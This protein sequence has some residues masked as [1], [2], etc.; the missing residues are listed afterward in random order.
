MKVEQL[1]FYVWW[2]SAGEVVYYLALDFLLDVTKT[3]KKR[4][5]MLLWLLG[6]GLM[7]GAAV[8]WQVP[9]MFLVDLLFLC[10]FARG[11]FGIAWEKLTAP[12]LIL[13]TLYTFLEGFSAVTMSWI[14]RN[15]M[16]EVRGRA[17]QMAVSA[18]LDA[19]YFGGLWFLRRRY[20]YT[21]QKPISSYLYI[22]L[23]PGGLMVLSIRY[24][25]KLDS[26]AFEEYLSGFGAGMEVYV[27]LV[28][29]GAV[30]LFFVMIEV[31]CKIIALTEC[32]QS[33]LILKSQVEGQ[34]IYVEEA[35]KRQEQDASFRHDIHNHLLVLAG[36]IHEE[37]Y[38]KAQEYVK[39]LHL[40]CEAPSCPVSTGSAALDVLLGEKVGFARQNHVEV[41]CSV[42]IPDPCH[43]DDMDLCVV[44]ANVM[45]NA[46]RASMESGRDKP[47][48]AITTS[49]RSRFLVVTAVNS[50]SGHGT[51]PMGTGL[52]NVKSIAEKYGGTMEIQPGEDFRISILL[53]QKEP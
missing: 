22:L 21:L 12:A 32:E 36:L 17:A 49:C 24:G 50:S 27:L 52:R 28:M 46:I 9:G 20:G 16:S 35:R 4:G 39:Q 41:T 1:I 14:S 3:E 23:L 33:A 18:L 44:F 53:C 19:L 31:F 2:M 48:L 38:E 8:Y 5:P 42:R 26:P 25:L 15:M 37:H 10:L 45:D 29:I 47:Y 6:N 40:R 34:R 13:F 51:V 11:V 43:I 7:I 30:C